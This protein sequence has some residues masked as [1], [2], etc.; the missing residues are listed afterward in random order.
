MTVAAQGTQG[1]VIHPLI[2]QAATVTA[3][4]I[5]PLPKAEAGYKAVGTVTT[6]TVFSV[7]TLALVIWLTAVG[8]V[9]LVIPMVTVTLVRLM[10]TMTDTYLAQRPRK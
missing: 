5:F 10:R 7:D 2:T 1:I 4:V 8:W 3:M 6:M 9:A